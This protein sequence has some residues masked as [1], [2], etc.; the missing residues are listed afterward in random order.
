MAIRQSATMPAGQAVDSLVL[1]PSWNLSQLQLVQVN[2]C[3]CC[4]AW[5][6]AVEGLMLAK[7]SLGGCS[8][9]ICVCFVWVQSIIAMQRLQHKECKLSSMHAQHCCARLVTRWVL[10]AAAY[11]H[12]RKGYQEVA[13]LCHCQPTC[14]SAACTWLS[15][16]RM[17]FMLSMLESTHRRQ[18]AL[19]RQT[20]TNKG[21]RTNS[22]PQEGSP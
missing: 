6:G 16:C 3:G 10:S 17:G 4:A 9:A 22:T 1:V 11:A 14:D 13:R 21:N 8:S 5:E 19:I 12:A 18:P 2:M 7:H 15:C 20:H